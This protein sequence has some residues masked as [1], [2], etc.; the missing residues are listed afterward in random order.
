MANSSNDFTLLRDIKMPMRDG[1]LRC[2]NV[3][4]PK[5]E[6]PFPVLLERTPYDKENSPEM[7]VG[8]P[9]FF[10]SHGYAVVTQYRMPPTRPPHRRAM[11]SRE[12]SANY[13]DEW[14]YH[15]GACELGFMWGWSVM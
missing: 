10:A 11:V 3:F 1:T 6:G 4:M 15:G 2:A 13:R 7:Q 14:V 8:A 5:G 9:P 12:S